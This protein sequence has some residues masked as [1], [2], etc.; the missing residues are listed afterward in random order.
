MGINFICVLATLLAIVHCKDTSVTFDTIH[1]KTGR[2][3]QIKLEHQGSKWDVGASAA[4][5]FRG[6]GGGSFSIR[7]GNWKFTARGTKNKGSNPDFGVS[8][9]WMFKRSTDNDENPGYYDVMII[10]NQ[11][12]FRMYDQDGDDLI[13]RKEMIKLFVDS[14]LGFDLFNDL[15]NIKGDGGITKKE[16]DS[17]SPRI[18]KGCD[19]NP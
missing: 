12:H 2:Q 13:T 17:M 1:T 18:I 5:D 3:L 14:N 8:V 9:S 19:V 16:F 10:A 4:T 11:C 15:D 6:N 7:K